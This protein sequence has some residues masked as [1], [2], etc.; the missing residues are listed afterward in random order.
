MKVCGNC[1]NQ[2]ED[3]E[4]ICTKCGAESKPVKSSSSSPFSGL[5]GNLGGGL[6][7]GDGIEKYLKIAIFVASALLVIGV[8]FPC[9]GVS[10]LGFKASTNFIYSDGSVL[11][12]VFFLIL[13]IIS[14]VFAFLGKLLPNIIC[15]GLSF[16]FW[17]YELIHINN[18]GGGMVNFLIGWWI[19]T[20]AVFALVGASVALFIMDKKKNV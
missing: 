5:G 15:G 1:G 14:L 13:G 7:L 3:H 8:F 11:D 10:F 20:L 9:I 18:E 12:G 2:M 17:L 16:L 19:I 6:Q 4:M